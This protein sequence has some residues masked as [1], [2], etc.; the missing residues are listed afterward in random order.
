M[1]EDF[2]KISHLY[3]IY[4]P[5]NKPSNSVTVRSGRVQPGRFIVLNDSASPEMVIKIYFNFF[6][7]FL[8]VLELFQYR[9]GDHIF[10]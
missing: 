5:K 6:R 10:F 1:N 9:R 8:K 2:V 3:L 4:F 7:L